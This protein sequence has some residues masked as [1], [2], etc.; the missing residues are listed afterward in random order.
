[1]KLSWPGDKP[2][3]KMPKCNFKLEKGIMEETTGEKR[4]Q[5]LADAYQVIECTWV[6]ELD[7]AENDKA[8]IEDGYRDS[9]NFWFHKH[10]RM[11]AELLPIRKASLESVR[12]AAYWN[13][14]AE[15]INIAGQLC[16][17]LATLKI[18]DVL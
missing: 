12:Y 3:D 15:G 10:R 11:R 14:I 17:L 18:K 5:V 2:A 8:G 9:K 7:G 13:W 16:L 1:M 4:P 6:R